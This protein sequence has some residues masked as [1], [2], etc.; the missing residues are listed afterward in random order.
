M[1]WF[2]ARY[3]PVLVPTLLF[4]LLVSPL[5]NRLE[6]FSW[7]A[8]TWPSKSPSTCLPILYDSSNH[9]HRSLTYHPEQPA[10]I[11]A[12]IKTLQEYQTD[13][14]SSGSPNTVELVDVAEHVSSEETTVSL[15]G[16]HT[17]SPFTAQELEHA[18]SVL[19]QIHNPDLVTS[20]EKRC[21]GSRQRRIEEGKD[22][23]GFVGYIDDDTYVTTETF[24]V[25]LRA[26]AAWIRAVDLVNTQHFLQSSESSTIPTAVALTRPPGHHATIAMSNGFC[27]F[28]FAA[29]AAF[30]FQSTRSDLSQVKISILDWDVH[31]G[32]V[33]AD[34]VS[35]HPEIIR[36]ATIHQ[37]PAFPYLGTKREIQ[38]NI[39]TIPIIAETTWTCGYQQCFNEALNFLF[40]EE[41]QLELVIVCA[42][43]DGLDSDELA[44]VSLHSSDYGRMTRALLDRIRLQQQSSSG[45]GKAARLILGMEGGYQLQEMA[46]GG[47]LQQAV[48]ETIKALLE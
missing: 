28:N 46:G 43:Y 42:G 6:G 40:S 29:A 4:I 11:E 32:Q 27:L 37:T 23:L 41:W 30:H 13:Q 33:V 34:I 36:Y 16:L 45:S 25:C 8:S 7:T 39:L 14:I 24:D 10:R 48:L 5:P 9:L 3:S 35:K 1:A 2:K 15:T 44:S 12:C 47:N 18:Q 38:N 21:R 20:L 17:H 22:P 19:L 26:T 31:M